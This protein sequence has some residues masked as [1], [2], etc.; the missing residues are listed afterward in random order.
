MISGSPPPPPMFKS[1]P[2]IKRLLLRL[3]ACLA[4]ISMLLWAAFELAVHQACIPPS[5]LADLPGTPVLL[6]CR[7]RL[8]AELPG[9]E[10]RL[11]FPVSSQDMNPWLLRAT[12]GLEDRRFMLHQGF[13]LPAVAAA[14]WSNLRSGRVVAGASTIT[15]QLIKNA[16]PR[17]TRSLGTKLDEFFTAIKLERQWSKEQILQRYLNLVD[18][19]NRF[20]GVEAAARQYFGKSAN[21][22][23]PQECIFLAALPR[24]P[25][26]YNPW[27]HSAVASARYQSALLRHGRLHPTSSRVSPPSG[28]HPTLSHGSASSRRT[29]LA[30]CIAPLISACSPALS[31]SSPS[32]FSASHDMRPKMPPF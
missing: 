2:R 23:T 17:R 12:I 27:R 21:L 19:G 13:D 20:L 26:R 10:A 5:L 4:L 16:R 31:P 7:G 22:L 9:K 6:D 8:I 29:L 30:G 25:T 28:R 18:Y 14:L 3:L 11:Q 24:A 15:Q 1:L 32:I